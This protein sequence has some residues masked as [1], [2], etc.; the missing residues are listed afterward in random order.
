MTLKPGKNLETSQAFD[1]AS[2]ALHLAA[3]DLALHEP[4]LVVR[5][6]LTAAEGYAVWRL[7]MKQKE[8]IGKPW[9]NIGKS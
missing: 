9:E 2:S 3:V 7:L 6:M 5:A 1:G 4:R 8:T